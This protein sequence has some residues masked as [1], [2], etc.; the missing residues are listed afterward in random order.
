[1]F[2]LSIYTFGCLTMNSIKLYAEVQIII[3]LIIAIEIC[4]LIYRSHVREYQ[5]IRVVGGIF[6][7]IFAFVMLHF[8]KRELETILCV[9]R[10]LH[11]FV[12]YTP[13]RASILSWDY[14][15]PFCLPKV[16]CNCFTLFST[17]EITR[18]AL[19]TITYSTVP[20]ISALSTIS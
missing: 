11:F 19:P 15:I 17:P 8:L 18:I 6:R 9:H 1:M 13:Q 16:S 3:M 20:E 14:A 2:H 7:Y 5:S 4:M 12:A 10:P